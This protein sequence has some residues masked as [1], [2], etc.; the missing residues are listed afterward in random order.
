MRAALLWGVLLMACGPRVHVADAGFEDAGEDAGVDAGRPRGDDPDAG[1]QVALAI[2]AMAPASS[3]WGVSVS[4]ALDQFQQPMIAALVVDPNGD[5]VFDDNRLVFTRWDGVAHVYQ[6]P[7]TVE[8]VGN[9]DVTHPKRQVSL[10]R[11]A[12]TNRLGVAYIKESGALRF[13]WSDDEGAHWSLM[14]IAMDPNTVPSNPVLAMRA[15]E[16]DIAYVHGGEVRNDKNTGGTDLDMP[17]TTT[18]AVDW[19]IAMAL[20][21]AGDPAVVYFSADDAGVTLLYQHSPVAQ[22]ITTTTATIDKA[23]SVSLDL[24]GDVPHVAYHLPSATNPD[25]QLW[26]AKAVDTSGTSWSTPV[27]MPRNGPPGMLD[28]TQW[29]QAIAVQMPNTPWVV[30]N[31]QNR[32]AVTAQQCGGPK[33]GLSSDGSNWM[34]CHPP[35]GGG[36]LV[37]T[38]DFAGWWL[39]MASHKSG[40]VT[41][42]F[43]Y[44]TRTNPLIGGG[45]LV[46]RQP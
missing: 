5:G 46:Y 12:S 29:Y 16:R 26:Y 38:F 14:T 40:K 20:P 10:A 6:A 21:S 35:E 31:F 41:I 43:D 34:V 22:V 8:V 24:T 42:A 15:G 32:T 33:L 11:D 1:W 17:M 9:I 4:M 18:A 39:N 37:H 7:V 44:E 28:G 45:V 3:R 30:G 36:P 23:P 25:G 27:A 2:P 13:G 19:P